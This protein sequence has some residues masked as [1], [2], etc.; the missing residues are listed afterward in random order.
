MFRQGAVCDCVQNCKNY[1][2]C[3][4]TALSINKIK[5]LQSPLYHELKDSINSKKEKTASRWLFKRIYNKNVVNPV[6][7]V[8]D[9]KRLRGYYYSLLKLMDMINYNSCN[10]EGL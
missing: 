1:G 8:E 5:I 7:K 3:N 10:K 2:V 9:Y 4:V 6:G